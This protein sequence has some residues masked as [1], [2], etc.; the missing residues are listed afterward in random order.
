[1]A[2]PTPEDLTQRSVLFGALTGHGKAAVS[3]TS[4][5]VRS[6]LATVYGSSRNANGVDT[7]EAARRLGVRQRTVQRWIRGDNAP[8]EEHLKALRTRSRQAAT[9]KRGRARAIKR[10]IAG[11]RITPGGVRVKV[12]GTQGPSGYLRDRGIQQKLTPEEY[13]GLLE[14]YSQGGDNAALDYLQNVLSDKYVDDWRFGN[15]N[16]F[17]VNGV[18]PNDQ[19]DDPRASR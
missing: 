7:K 19:A 4:N 11:Q 1:M 15:V 12:A 17:Q 14:V 3:G 16:G 9:T 6:M 2:K 5:D 18:G 8:S 10:A 13:Q